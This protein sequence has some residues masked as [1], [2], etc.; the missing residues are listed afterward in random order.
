MLQLLD[1]ALNSERLSSLRPRI[2]MV[3]PSPPT[4]FLPPVDSY[5]IEIENKM[6]KLYLFLKKLDAQEKI[7]DFA[8][9]VFGLEK[10]EAVKIFITLLFLAQTGK[11]NLRQE[12]NCSDI[13]IKL[14]EACLIEKQ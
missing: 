10:L 11:V 9:L 1:G 2:K 4:D 3:L 14:P 8:G 13:Y 6:R 5:I 7:I 12:E